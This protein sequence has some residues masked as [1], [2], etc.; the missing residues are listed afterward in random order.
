MS[1]KKPS[2]K[3]LDRIRK[4]FATAD[5]HPDSPEGQLA[6]GMARKK[7][8]EINFPEAEVRLCS[9]V[10]LDR[11]NKDWE[12]ILISS[13]CVLEGVDMVRIET[14][15]GL[16]R[17]EAH[18]SVCD[19]DR[20]EV[21]W[22]EI[23]RDLLRR[24]GDYSRLLRPY[25]GWDGSFKAVE[26]YLTWAASVFW[27]SISEEQMAKAMARALQ[28]DS[29]GHSGDDVGDGE[30][31]SQS[32]WLDDAIASVEGLE[33][34]DRRIPDHLSPVVHG[35]SAGQ[36]LHAEFCSGSDAVQDED[37]VF[38]TRLLTRRPILISDSGCLVRV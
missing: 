6:L 13:V 34:H 24:S 19:V 31:S 35:S 21:R 32:D 7:L 38:E 30:G 15:D 5:R 27:A 20:L 22:I 36:E 2:K 8:A 28:E 33:G 4:L 29:E 1:K 9:R 3:V 12:A 25:M 14:P 23:R 18:G 16:V 37:S 17:F 11:C 26:V 10:L